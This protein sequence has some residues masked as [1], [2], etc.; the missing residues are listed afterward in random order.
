MDEFFLCAQDFSDTPFLVQKEGAIKKR[1][2]LLSLQFFPK[3]VQ[4]KPE[5][6]VAVYSFSRMNGDPSA[7][8]VGKDRA[9]LYALYRPKSPQI[10]VD[11]IIC[12]VKEKV[13]KS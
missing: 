3:T 9:D 6:S 13:P 12:Y 7:Q 2:A 11:R 5:S 1:N 8:F 10:I 4:K